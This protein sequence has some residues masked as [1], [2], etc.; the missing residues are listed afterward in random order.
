MAQAENHGREE[1]VQ[2]LGLSTGTVFQGLPVQ[3]AVSAYFTDEHGNRGP[4]RG[5]AGGVMKLASQSGLEGRREP[6]LPSRG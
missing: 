6:D 4:E 2:N 1:K 3:C 5:G